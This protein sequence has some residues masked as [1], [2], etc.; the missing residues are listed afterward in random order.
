MINRAEHHLKQAMPL[1]C[2]LK[3]NL[4]PKGYTRFR[5]QASLN[6]RRSLRKAGKHFSQLE[7]QTLHCVTMTEKGRAQGRK[8]KEQLENRQVV[9]PTN[10]LK[11][12]VIHSKPYPFLDTVL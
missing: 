3:T 7:E 8:R 9:H 11:Q 5:N 2:L 1:V 10:Q 6:L 4:Q 12:F